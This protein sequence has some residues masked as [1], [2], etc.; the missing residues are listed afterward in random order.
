MPRGSPKGTNRGGGKPPLGP[1]HGVRLDIPMA[2]LKQIDKARG[3][4]PR[5]NWIRDAIR[6]RLTSDS[7]GPQ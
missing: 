7:T 6:M 5:T 4:T 1:A 2:M 3:R